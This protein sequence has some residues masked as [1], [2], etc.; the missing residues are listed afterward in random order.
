MPGGGV[1]EGETVVQAAVREA[2][3]ELGVPIRLGPLRAIIH[4]RLADG[5]MQRHWSFEADADTDDIVIAAGPEA[6]G[7]PERGTYRAIW[8]DLD[9][10]EPARIWPPAL[11]SLL[12]ANK[13]NWPDAVTEVC[14]EPLGE[15]WPS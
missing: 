5:S 10:L 12:A 8:L 6:A 1:E 4:C 13:G 3:E 7:P 15:P 9:Q 11:A 14:Q 2:A